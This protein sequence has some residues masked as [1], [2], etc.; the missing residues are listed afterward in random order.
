M[1]SILSRRI[2]TGI[3]SVFISG[4]SFCF[5]YA[6]ISGTLPTPNYHIIKKIP[7]GGEGRWD[8]LTLDSAA[9]RL[10]ITRSTRVTV[11]NVDTGLVVGEIPHTAGVHGVAIAP[12]LSRGFTSNGK[13][14]TATIFDLKTLQ[15]IGEVK[16]GSNPDAIVYDAVS[17]KVFTFNGLSNSATVFDA[18]T[19]KVLGTIALGGKP[20]FAAADGLGQIFV[21]LEDK[22]EVV[23]INASNLQVKGHW[24]LKPCSE[25][26]GIAIDRQHQRLFIGCTN[27]LMSV[28]DANT[29][30]I[31]ATLPIGKRTDAI[32]YDPVT[33]LAFSSNGEGSLTVVHED[34]AD[35]FSIVNNVITQPGARTMA[36]D[37]KTHKLY[38]DT[39]KFQA[40]STPVAGK[41]RSRPSIIPG[42]F[43]ILVLGD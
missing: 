35:K 36:L 28:V 29:G 2:G 33:R 18:K 10:Y 22:N 24:A 17:Q 6:V 14:A 16:T 42:T 43:V 8:Y 26:T 30:S 4:L 34:S 12:E 38:L 11:L 19:T 5:H 32:A 9:R 3:A 40:K 27:Q 31:K 39:A 7:L 15:V 37:L 41:E 23:A 1:N 25:P 21:N 13:T 20:E